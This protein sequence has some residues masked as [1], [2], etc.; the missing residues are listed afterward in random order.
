MVRIFLTLFIFFSHNSEAYDKLAEI[1]FG[2]VWAV[3]EQ[4][5]EMGLDLEY[6]PE[7]FS[8]RF[9]LGLATEIEFEKEKEFYAGPLLSVY[10]SQVK[11]FM[12]SGL[13]G[14]GSYWR[15]KSRLGTGYDF[16]LPNEYLLIPN[17]TFD[18]IDDEIHPGVSVGVAKT[19]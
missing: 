13:Q 17:L 15:L 10:L 5:V 6:F 19:F 16:H 8:H 11:V 9:S 4:F 18:F 7:Q 1:T 12:T 3:D 14:H 2:N